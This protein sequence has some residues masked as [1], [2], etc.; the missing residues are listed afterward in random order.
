MYRQGPVHRV[1]RPLYGP[2]LTFMIPKHA[3][4]HAKHARIQA[5]TGFSRRR[6]TQLIALFLRLRLLGVVL[7]YVGMK[8]TRI[9]GFKR[10]PNDLTTERSV[11]QGK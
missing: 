5:K 8:G 9:R 6:K 1:F 10:H 3:L 7:P 11:L 4:I 2:G